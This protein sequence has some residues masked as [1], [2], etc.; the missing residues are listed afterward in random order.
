MIRMIQSRAAE[1]AKAYFSDALSKS[2]Y[3]ISDQEL[4]GVWEG[5]LAQRLGVSGVVGKD[6]FFALCE[7]LHP[8]TGESLTPRQR[9]DRTTGYD[10]NFH[11][12]KSVSLLHVFAGD[13]HILKAF[14][15]SVHETMLAMEA[16]SKT[17]VRKGGVSVD[18]DAGELI[19]GHFVHQTARPVDGSVP[20]PHLHS[21]C[22]V[23]NATWDDVEGR[24][25]A[26]QFRDIKRDMP[27]YQAMFHKTL[28]DRLMD[29]GYAVRRTD[30]SFEIVGVPHKVTELFSKRTD[31]I[32]RIAKEKG[33]TD[34]KEKSELGA[35]T[36][37]K[38]QKSHSMDE[39]RAAWKD[40]IAALGDAGKSGAGIV[41]FLSS[42]SK[43][44]L[45]YIIASSACHASGM[46]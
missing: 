2:D 10:I 25:K 32:G 44:A 3:Y 46:G 18:R 24:I 29:L 21:H 30:K 13:G 20:D 26:A 4:A 27:Y 38:K 5:R 17:R 8:K 33:I 16:D 23:F 28:A 39:L 7:N 6:A 37:A 35:R 41:C 34:A 9:A 40:Q 19:W 43:L 11:A 45:R 22:F 1:Q 36:R 14:Q 31:E 42:V 12:P 15:D